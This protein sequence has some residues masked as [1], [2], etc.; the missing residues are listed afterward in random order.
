[1]VPAWGRGSGDRGRSGRLAGVATLRALTDVLGSTVRPAGSQSGLDADVSEVFLVAPGEPLPALTGTLLLCLDSTDP[2]DLLTRAADVGATALVVKD[3]DPDRWASPKVPVLVADPA[4]P[5][6]HLTQLLTAAVGRPTDGPSGGL[7][8][9]FALAGAIAAMVGGAVAIEDPQRRVLAY[10]SAPEHPIDEARRQGILGRRVPDL[11]RNDSLYRTMQKAPGVVRFEADGDVLPRIAVAVRSG[12]EL[13]GSIW[14]VEGEP[15]GAEAEAALLGASRLA[16]LHLLRVR[17]G[18]DVERRSRGEL[19]RGLLEGR[20]SP[21]LA[22]TRLRLD[23][24][25]PVVMLGFALTGPSEDDGAEAVADLVQLQCASLG[26]RSAV[27][28]E[29]GTVYALVQADVPRSRLL[30]LGRAV[31]DRAR[32][33]TKVELA[34]AVGATV[35]NV[36]QVGR[37][38]ADVDAVLRLQGPGE[39]AAVEDVLPQVVLLDLQAHFASAPHLRLEAVARMVAHD[40]EHGSPYAASVLAYLAAGGEVSVAAE[41]VS[42]HANTFRYRLRRA[43]ELFD[44]DLDDPDVRLVTWLQLRAGT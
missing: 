29:L 41:A 35:A 17:A 27:L 33:G 6:Q 42:V 14:V 28:V 26:S 15:L 1:M 34:G 25:R 13:L 2:D 36:H 12:P 7:G 40:A 9:L 39:V 10:S 8:D 37:S 43:R 5:W 3:G 23:P 18:V 4:V 31:V 16:A 32:S 19:L 24:H 11:T 21:D 30:Q 22:A 20:S 44:L 38:R